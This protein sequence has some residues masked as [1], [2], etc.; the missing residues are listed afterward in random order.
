MK[1]AVL[2]VFLLIGLVY[3]G[4]SG[5]KCLPEKEITVN[6]V[7]SVLSPVLGGAKIVQVSKSPVKDIYEVVVEARGRKIPVYIDCTLNYLITG[8]IIDLKNKKS[9]TREKVRKLAEAEMKKKMELLEKKLGKERVEK[10]KKALGERFADIKIVD[11]KDIPK[12]HLITYGNPDAEYTVY[13]ITDPECP[14]CAKFDKEMQ[15][16][17]KKR[18]DVKFEVILFPLPFHK[19]ASKISQRIVCEKSV[20]KKKE[21]LGES[22]EAVRK[23]NS[24]KLEELGESCKEGREAIAKHLAFGKLTGIGGTPTLIFPYGITVSGWMTAEQINKV[25]DALK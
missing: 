11:I 20:E 5:E 18:K 24:K 1:K 16:V 9:I 21:I 7:E 15:K 2:S 12:E 14:F 10:L 19:H 22:F 25:L 4:F 23:N 13:V 6:K 8:E 17:L 3:S